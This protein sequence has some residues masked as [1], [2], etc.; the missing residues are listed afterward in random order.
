MNF[1]GKITKKTGDTSSKCP[2][3]MFP[4]LNN[5]SRWLVIFSNKDALCI[6]ALCLFQSLI[7]LN[8]CTSYNINIPLTIIIRKL[9]FTFSPLILVLVLKCEK[10]NSQPAMKLLLL[11]LFVVMAHAGL[12]PL[13]MAKTRGIPNSFIIKIKVSD[14]RF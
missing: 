12:A 5:H 6:T 1:A 10:Q 14:D 9:C 8:N 3:K 13:K 11:C 2:F 4:Y 7:F